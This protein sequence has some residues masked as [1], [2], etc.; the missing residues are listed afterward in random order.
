MLRPAS[1]NVPV[2]RLG[3][4]ASWKFEFLSGGVRQRAREADWPADH[5]H[6]ACAETAGGS[7]RG[8]LRL[9]DSFCEAATRNLP[10]DRGRFGSLNRCDGSNPWGIWHLSVTIPLP[11]Q[12]ILREK[13]VLVYL[14]L[15]TWKSVTNACPL[16]S[17]SIPPRRRRSPPS[18]RLA[19]RREFKRRLQLFVQR[20]QMLHTLALGGEPSPAVQAVRR[21][22]ERLVRPAQVRRHQIRVVEIGQRRARMGG[23]GVEHGLSRRFKFRQI[24]ALRRRRE[25]IVDEA[26]GIAVTTFQPP[27]DMAQPG[28]VHGR[29]QQ[30]E[31]RQRGVL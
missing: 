4:K 21:A 2:T 20:E 18:F 10:D 22:V 8:D 29:G 19:P 15:V 14:H 1:A 13:L 31:I 12:P 26:D 28:H 9:R 25:G 17:P 23:A 27:A 24:R 16:A 30:R 7:L 6:A 3:Q 5:V 11:P